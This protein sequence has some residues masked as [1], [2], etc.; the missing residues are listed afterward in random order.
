MT[1]VRELQF[2]YPDGELIF[3]GLTIDFLQGSTAIMGASGSG[4]STLLNLLQGRL[5]P[6]NGQVEV[7]GRDLSSLRSYSALAKFRREHLGVIQQNPLF[8]DELDAEHNVALSVAINGEPMR[9]ALRRARNLLARCKI[10]PDQSVTTLSGGERSRVAVCRALI[11]NPEIVLADEPSAALDTATARSIMELL[12][13]MS[14]AEVT[15]V[16]THDNAVAH[17]CDR[18]IHL[19]D[20]ASAVPRLFEKYDT[21]DLAIPR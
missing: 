13:E 17:M 19:E 4:K 2:R 6:M 16:V 20:Y 15:I 9:S 11:T 1:Y 3:D 18:I 5:R 10:K 8:I 21:S 7:L 12:L 14:E